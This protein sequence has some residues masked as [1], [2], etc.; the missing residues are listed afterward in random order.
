MGLG[1]AA[2][3]DDDPDGP[4]SMF[5]LRAMTGDSKT[6]ARVSDAP[7]MGD[8]ELAALEAAASSEEEEVRNACCLM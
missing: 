5:N 7:V 3:I 6:L 4:D 2:P 1:Q 8:K